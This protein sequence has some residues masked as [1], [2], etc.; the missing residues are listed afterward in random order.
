MDGYLCNMAAASCVL[1]PL[2]CFL[3][4]RYSKLELKVLKNVIMDFYKPEDVSEA[5]SQLKIDVEHVESRLCLSG[6]PRMPRRAEGEQRIVHEIDDIISLWTFMDEHKI[7]GQL[8]CYVADSP[9]SMP[10]MRMVDSDFKLLV[11][12]VDKMQAMLADVMSVIFKVHA[13]IQ[14]TPYGQST[15]QGVIDKPSGPL[16]TSWASRGSDITTVGRD[17]V[18]NLPRYT[19]DFPVLA[20]SSDTP[21]RNNQVSSNQSLNEAASATSRVRTTQQQYRNQDGRTVGQG[22]QD[23]GGGLFVPGDSR[24]HR[25]RIQNKRRRIRSREDRAT[26]LSDYTTDADADDGGVSERGR[27][28][29][30]QSIESSRRVIGK[31]RADTT[32]P[33]RPKLTA[34][35]PYLGKAVFRVDNVSTDVNED[36]LSRY[37]CNMGISV[38]SCYKVQPRRAPWQRQAGIMPRDRSTFRLCVAREDVDKLLNDQM[39]PEHISVSSWIFFKSR[40]QQQQQQQQQTTNDG[41]VHSPNN[42]Q[43]NQHLSTTTTAVDA[44]AMSDSD[45]NADMDATIITQ[46][47][48]GDNSGDS[49]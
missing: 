30:T 15:G 5:K 12:R 44:T 2:L 10:Y 38:I 16:T 36:D 6:R 34:A 24:T 42:R 45:N 47:E 35:K 25:Q 31:K 7:T 22:E 4:K 40:Q 19:E 13:A 29:R 8:P 20:N 49:S 3:A 48:H 37:V 14:T 21:N 46:E 28:K 33:F 26:G 41:S 39:W 27:V 9:D 17:C 1:S 23:D 32:L 43:H 18:S 11:E